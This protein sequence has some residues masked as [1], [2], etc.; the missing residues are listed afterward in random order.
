MTILR[1]R[2]RWKYSE[3]GSWNHVWFNYCYYRRLWAGSCLEA[4]SMQSGVAKMCPTLK[5]QVLGW[6]F[7]PSPNYL[8]LGKSFPP[9]GFSF[10]IYQVKRMG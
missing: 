5:V 7:V 1:L 3:S 2:I 8:P 9:L 4:L 10:L 6:A